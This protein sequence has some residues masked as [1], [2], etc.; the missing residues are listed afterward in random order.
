MHDFVCF[1]FCLLSII[2]Q[3]KSEVL[4]NAPLME[5]LPVCLASG[6]ADVVH[7]GL[8]LLHD[9]AVAGSDQDVAGKTDN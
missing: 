2:D 4:D 6:E 1:L 9:L 8:V 3:F 5:H 7:W